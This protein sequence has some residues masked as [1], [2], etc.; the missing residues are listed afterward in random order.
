MTYDKIHDVTG[1]S[2]S[3]IGKVVRRAKMRKGDLHDA[4]RSGRPPKVTTPIKKRIDMLVEEHPRATLQQIA[5]FADCGISK[6]TVN[7]TIHELGYRLIIPR[8]KP[9]LTDLQKRKRLDWCLKHRHWRLGYW[10]RVCWTDEAK[11]EFCAIEPGKRVRCKPGQELREDLL[12]PSF[13]SGRTTVGCWAAYI[14]GSRTPLFLVRKRQPSERVTPKDALGTNG[15]QYGAEILEPYLIPYLYSQEDPLDTF[16]L[17]EDG[18]PYHRTKLNDKLRASYNIKNL[19]WPPSSPDLNPIENAWN[20]LKRKLHKRW[21]DEEKRPHSEAELLQ[22]ME[23]EWEGLEQ[24]RFDSWVE[25]M[26][27]RIEACIAANGGHTK[28]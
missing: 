18:A 4:P 12:A 9:Y 23:E 28:W 6:D 5:T 26:P 24:T 27:D 8:T 16:Y 7:R 3:T 21:A 1:V 10:K 11:V 13:K 14:Y 2:R 17:M 22:A 25:S 15:L 19:P 20:S